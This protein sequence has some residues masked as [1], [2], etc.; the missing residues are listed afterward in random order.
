MKKL[1]VLP[2]LVLGLSVMAQNYSKDWHLNY[3]PKDTVYGINLINALNEVPKPANAKPVIVAVID[4]GVDVVHPDIKANLW[5]NT[6]DIPGNAVDDDHNG[7]IDDVYG[8]DFLG[9]LSKDINYDNLEMTRQLRNYKAKFGN[10]TSKEIAKADKAEFKKYKELEEK[11]NKEYTRIKGN[12][13][14][15]QNLQKYLNAL[16]SEL[17]S[18]NISV[19]QLEA[20]TPSTP[21]A[22]YGHAIVSTYC[23][24]LGMNPKGV[25]EQIKGGYDYFDAQYN[26]HYNLD[27]DPRKIIGDD[28]NNVADNKYGNNEV[29]GP[30]GEHGTHV[31]GIIGAVRDNNIGIQGIAPM[32]QIMVLR[33]VPDGDERDKDVAHA[34]R[35]AADNGAKVINMSFGKAYSH[36]KAAVDAAI[37]YA[38]SKDVLIIHAAGNDNKN[39]DKESNF[40]TPRYLDG[41]TCSTW[42]EVGASD[43]DQN[44]ASFSNYGKTT[45]NVFA[46]GVQ[47]YS[48]VPD[49][50]YE[51]FDGTSMAAPVV[52]GVAGLIR[53]YY[54][55]L[56]AVQ[57]KQAI[58]STVIK[59][60]MK[61]KL[62]G[63][64]KKKTKYKK[65]CTTAG[66]VNAAAALKAASLMK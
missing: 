39:T 3:A 31:A 2:A 36:D 66:I 65:L 29:K 61:V 64:K 62:P 19:A 50:K 13:T 24:K 38:E 54:P 41:S 51:A 45:V 25:F 26:Y 21:D 5:T 59:P 52:A 30:E 56:N 49:N 47:I 7:Y 6:K 55:N 17:D 9:S 63:T 46:P 22:K 44:P 10:K 28:Y 23:S 37:K 32:V 20:F 42:I 18:T 16:K 43:K 40:P 60:E 12:F 34:I 57:V 58:E 11:F 14:Y 35:Y 33:V 27:Y 4:N 48:T 15:Y 1:L 8:W 53:A